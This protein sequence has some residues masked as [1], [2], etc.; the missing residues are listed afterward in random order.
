ETIY[1][2]YV[3]D[4]NNESKSLYLS[5]QFRVG[6]STGT[7]VRLGEQDS[8]EINGQAMSLHDGDEFR[9]NLT[10]T[11]YALNA[12]TDSL[13]NSYVFLWKQGT[14]KTITNTLPTAPSVAI[15]LPA[16][17]ATISKKEGLTVEFDGQ[18]LSPDEDVT[19]YL[20]STENPTPEQ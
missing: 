15:Q 2:R 10:G 3:A 5:A 16:P 1:Q 20:E 4:Y 8:I 7:T 6:G 14:G 12:S 19:F 11:F 13:A 18:D 17:G 9:P